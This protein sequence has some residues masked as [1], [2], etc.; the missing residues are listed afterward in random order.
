MLALSPLRPHGRRVYAIDS[1]TER[2]R[3]HLSLGWLENRDAVP[4]PKIQVLASQIRPRFPRGV[5]GLF[6]DK[7]LS[8]DL[9]WVFI[10]TTQLIA[11]PSGM[12]QHGVDTVRGRPPV[13]AN[14]L[15]PRDARLYRIAHQG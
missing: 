14:V 1:K 3:V 12:P 8:P 13:A 11:L 5:L 10:G 15:I 9:P 2:P 7:R 6:F 4:T